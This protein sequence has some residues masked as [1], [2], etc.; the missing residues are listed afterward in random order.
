M[1]HKHFF[2]KDIRALAPSTILIKTIGEEVEIK[3]YTTNISV[4]LDNNLSFDEISDYFNNLLDK[5]IS[6]MVKSEESI[7]LVTSGGLD[8]SYITALSAKYISNL[9][10]FNVAYEGN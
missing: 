6:Q 1:A 8:S 7:C 4:T 9:N 3:N 10:T 5:E 2:F